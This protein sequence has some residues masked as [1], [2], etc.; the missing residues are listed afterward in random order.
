MA[1]R[2]FYWYDG[3]HVRTQ[4]V[5]AFAPEGN[6]FVLP[7]VTEQELNVEKKETYLNVYLLPD[8]T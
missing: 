8:K 3:A 2:Y 7:I 1:T 6:R 5:P 4:Q